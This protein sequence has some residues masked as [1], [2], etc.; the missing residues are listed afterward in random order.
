MPKLLAL[1]R[2]LVRQGLLVD[3]ALAVA[4]DQQGGGVE[5][6][7]QPAD[8][9]QKAVGAGIDLALVGAR[10]LRHRGLVGRG[11]LGKAL[12]SGLDLVEERGH[13]GVDLEHAD[14]LVATGGTQR[15]VGGNQVAVLDHA[16]EG[17]EFVAVGQLAGGLPADGR[18]PALVVDRVLADLG[19]LGRIDRDPSQ[20]EDLDLEHAARAHRRVGRAVQRREPRQGHELPAQRGQAGAP[21]AVCRAAGGHRAAGVD[22]QPLRRGHEGCEIL[23]PQHVRHHAGQV[24]VAGL[25]HRQ[26]TAAGRGFVLARQLRLRLRQES[27]LLALHLGEKRFLHALQKIQRQ[28]QRHERQQGGDREVAHQP[29]AAGPIGRRRFG[30]GPLRQLRLLMHQRPPLMSTLPPPS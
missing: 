27:A 2:P 4:H 11:D 14:Q 19:V 17:A 22:R 6:R 25:V 23:L 18:A 29:K 16:L 21:W 8:D 3:D 30:P 15:H 7:Q 10:H 13:V 5:Q 28:R 1:R 12:R 9:G 24:D 20:V 26:Q